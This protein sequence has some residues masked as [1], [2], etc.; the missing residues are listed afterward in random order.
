MGVGG[1]QALAHFIC[2]ENNFRW[3]FTMEGITPF[4]MGGIGTSFLNHLWLG[5]T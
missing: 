4:L 1:V 3:E 5:E 2:G